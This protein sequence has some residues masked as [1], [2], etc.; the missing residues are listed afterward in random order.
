MIWIAISIYFVI[1]SLLFFWQVSNL[2]SVLYGAPAISS[3]KHELWKKFAD[4]E[5]TLLDLGC[6]I[7]SVCLRAAP[8]FKH[9]YGIEYSPMYY[10]ISKLRTRK[11]RNVTI[12]YGNMFRRSWPKVNYI[13]CYLMPNTLGKLKNKL[14]SSGAII[15]SYAFRIP[16]RESREIVHREKMALYVYD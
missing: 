1:V 11:N 15:L 4:K 5:K 14:E 13:Y 2:L 7:G 6:G 10:F 3:P 8:H 9:V 16:G 12:L